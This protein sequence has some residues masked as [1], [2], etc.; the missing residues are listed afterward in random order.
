[1]HVVKELFRNFSLNQN[2]Q[3]RC[4]DE[5]VRRRW[6]QQQFE[7][8]AEHPGDVLVVAARLQIAESAV[9]GA[10]LR[11]GE[12]EGVEAYVPQESVEQ[13]EVSGNNYDEEE[14]ST[15]SGKLRS[16]KLVG[17]PGEMTQQLRWKWNSRYNEQKL[18]ANQSLVH[19][20]A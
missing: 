6:R 3:Y 9:P 16:L 18:V 2:V 5:V 4:R 13:K 17:M 11:H 19:G 20:L 7:P 10:D 14:V 1:M 15:H 12:E 8:S